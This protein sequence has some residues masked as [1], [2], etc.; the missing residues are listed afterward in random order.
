MPKASVKADKSRRLQSVKVQSRRT[1]SLLVV[2][3]PPTTPKLAIAPVTI[4]N[5]TFNF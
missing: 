4:A 3:Q 5:N 1:F 2:N